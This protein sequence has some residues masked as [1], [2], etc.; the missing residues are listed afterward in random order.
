MNLGELKEIF[1]AVEDD[2]VTAFGFVDVFSWRG[3]YD[4]VCF[5]IGE[6]VPA[7]KSKL[8]IMRAMNDEF[9]GYKG[10]D[11]RYGSGTP[12]NFENSGS[13]WS[14]GEYRETMISRI[15]GGEVETDRDKYLAELIAK[16]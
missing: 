1:D 6:N 5:E 10:G 4:E 12:V 3:S 7:Y 2:K 8:M 15:V 13:S 9:C 16:S 14:D 11:Y